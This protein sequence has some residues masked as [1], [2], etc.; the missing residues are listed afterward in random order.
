MTR[1]PS[2]GIEKKLKNKLEVKSDRASDQVFWTK[3]D[4]EFGSELG[5]ESVRNRDT[6]AR[7]S[8]FSFPIFRWGT[9][10]AMLLVI[11][12]YLTTKYRSDQI[13]IAAEQAEIREM[14]EISD[15]LDDL[16]LF[17]AFEELEL[18]GDDWEILFEE[19]ENIDET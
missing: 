12:G 11:G 15:L 14:A 2:D 1:D 16:E 4:G 7:P 10:A 5:S 8:I 6:Q 3:F 17:M 13:R 18:S 19:E 9:I